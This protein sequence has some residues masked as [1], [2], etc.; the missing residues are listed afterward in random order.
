MNEQTQQE[1]REKAQEVRQKVNQKTHQVADKAKRKAGEAFDGQ[2][3]RAVGELDHLASALRQTSDNLRQQ[4]GSSIAVD[5]T[6]RLA[7]GLE[8]VSDRIEG[9]QLEEIFRDIENLAR[10]NPAVVYGTAAVIGFLA[11]RFFKSS[12]RDAASPVRRSARPTDV[13]GRTP[14]V[15]YAEEVSDE[16]RS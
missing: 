14:M 4:G 9:K 6:E 11:I 5:I 8:R 15:D 2:K 1:M 13:A 7:S 16:R 10:R 3:S 12:G